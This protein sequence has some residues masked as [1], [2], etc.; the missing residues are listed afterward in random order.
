MSTL[1]VDVVG[2]EESIFSGEAAYVSLPGVVGELGILPGHLPLITTINPGPVRIK[3]ADG[4]EENVFVAGGILEVQPDR[5][6]VLADVA[7]RSKDLDEAKAKKALEEAQHL[8][9]QAKSN[10]EIAKIEAQISS[11]AAQLRVIKRLRG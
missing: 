5:V 7:V 9:E 3:M 1:V 6:T 10:A 2:A 8:R 4:S 11:L